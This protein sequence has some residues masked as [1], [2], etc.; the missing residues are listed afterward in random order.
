MSA[1]LRHVAR[2]GDLE[3]VRAL[4]AAGEDPRNPESLMAAVRA[5]HLDVLGVLLDSGAEAPDPAVLAD[6]LAHAGHAQGRERVRACESLRRL[7]AAGGDLNAPARITGWPLWFNA[8]AGLAEPDPALIGRL[9]Q[10][11]A[12]PRRTDGNGRNAFL[13]FLVGLTVERERPDWVVKTAEVL[14]A[15][16]GDDALVLVDAGGMNA[17]HHLCDN[18]GLSGRLL[19][20][21][22]RLLC[23]RGADFDARV[24]QGVREGWTPLMLAVHRGHLE[25]ARLLLK[26]GADPDLK[27]GSAPARAAIDLAATRGAQEFV[28]LLE[29]HGGRLEPAMARRAQLCVHAAAHRSSEVLAMAEQVRRDFPDDFVVL[30]HIAR[31]HNRTGQHPQAL[32][33]AEEGLRKGGSLSFVT[34]AVVAL[35]GLGR[36]DE[37][38]DRWRSSWSQDFAPDVADADWVLANLISSYLFA[39]RS[40]EAASELLPLAGAV[41][42]PTP[43][44]LYNLAC[45]GAAAGRVEECARYVW[46][47]REREYS[48]ARFDEEHDF[49]PVRNHPLFRLAREHDLHRP[50]LLAVT[51]TKRQARSVGLAVRGSVVT[52]AGARRVDKRESDVFAAAARY[53]ELRQRYLADGYREVPDPGE[54]YWVATLEAYFAELAILGGPPLGALRLHWDHHHQPRTFQYWLYAETYEVVEPARAACQGGCHELTRVH[55]GPHRAGRGVPRIPAQESLARIAERV[56]AGKAF[57][58]LACRPVV[59]FLHEEHDAGLEFWVE[60]AAAQG[61]AARRRPPARPAEP[62]RRAGGSKRR[63]PAAGARRGGPGARRG[64]R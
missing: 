19:A 62:R 13:H 50:I 31:A 55:E 14:L 46:A 34:S 2:L 40:G 5:G 29:R 28:A 47:T 59:F 49:D 64:G 26:R 44:L 54:D 35:N 41:P 22:G 4:I 48:D 32:V 21:L 10:L 56:A 45:L 30:A 15:A 18:E 17:L 27:V 38:I 16:S 36:Y 33:L 24:S 58:R 42:H 23:E 3:A 20:R 51:L 39:N 60:V 7:V 9:L 8:L 25:L 12:D 61:P 63:P 37:A 1:Q 53:F 11:G 6:A 57:S 43:M 52:V